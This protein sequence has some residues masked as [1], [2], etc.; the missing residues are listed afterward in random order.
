MLV[1]IHAIFALSALGVSVYGNV[2]PGRNKLNASYGLAYVTLASG[3]LLIV[4]SHASIL[5]TCISGIAF[6]GIVS[7]LNELARRKLAVETSRQ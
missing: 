2:R 3:V 1:I 6:F 5:R 4:I 7:F